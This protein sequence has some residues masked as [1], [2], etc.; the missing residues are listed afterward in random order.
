MAIAITVLIMV[1]IAA[2][3]YPIGRRLGSR[4]S[5]GAASDRATTRRWVGATTRLGVVG[6]VALC[7]WAVLDSHEIVVLVVIVAVLTAT[8]VA[9]TW[10]HL[11]QP[12]DQD[13]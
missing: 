4:F 2:V 1:L 5:S 9:L 12:A 11:R 6:A 8:Q 7:A 3:F 10:R 13:H